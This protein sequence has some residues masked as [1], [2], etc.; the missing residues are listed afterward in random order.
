MRKVMLIAVLAIAVML[1]VSLSP[2]AGVKDGAPG[3][4]PLTPGCPMDPMRSLGR[5]LMDLIT[6]TLVPPLKIVKL[7]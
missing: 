6:L 1:V 7:S 3:H 5:V 4:N 2:A